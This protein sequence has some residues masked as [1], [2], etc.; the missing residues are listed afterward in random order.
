MAEI[1]KTHSTGMIQN[2]TMPK[3]PATAQPPA[4][5]QDR[6]KDLITTTQVKDMFRNALQEHSDSFL[7]SIVDLY[8]NDRNLQQCNPN[9]VL[10]EAFKA[11]T[12]KLP[13]NKQLG[14]AFL[15]PFRDNRLN[16]VVPTFQ[17]GYKG[18]IQLCMRTGAY[19]HIHAGPVYEG[20][21]VSEDR[22]TG[23]VDLSG[24]RLCDK[25]VGFSAYI[26][27]V[28]GFSKA[29]YWSVE[30][31]TAHA[32]RYSKSYGSSSSPWA[33]NFEEMGTKTILR[34]LLSRFGILSIEL[35]RAYI[36]DMGAAADEQLGA[37]A[38]ADVQDVTP[39]AQTVPETMD[40]MAMESEPA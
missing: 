20:E 1:K 22:L 6:L 7:A 9:E 25:V 40:P 23:E 3:A 14:F 4:P 27:T 11:A 13:I 12:L 24:E 15:V 36:A 37:P 2:A 39:L 29:L 19:K 8:N 31:M 16:K 32:K 28:N 33:T 26:E 5:R 18:Y 21:F 10:M 38:Y 30:R 17:L 34:S 35:E